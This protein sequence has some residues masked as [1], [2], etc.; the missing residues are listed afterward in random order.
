M[1][2]GR[3]GNRDSFNDLMVYLMQK[4]NQKSEVHG[5]K[6]FNCFTVYGLI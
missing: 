2:T 5:M 6:A 3:A 1:A 4:V